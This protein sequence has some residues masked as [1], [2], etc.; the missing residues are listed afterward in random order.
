MRLLKGRQNVLNGFESKIFP[1]EKQTKGHPLD[2]VCVAKVSDRTCLKIITP[3]PMLEKLPIA[4]AQV[5]IG[6]ASENLL[7]EIRKITY[8]LHPTKEIL[9]KVYNEFN[10]G[11]NKMDI[12]FMDSGNSKTSDPHRL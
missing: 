4:F 10:K 12:I 1:I 7:N 9:K 5:N 3:K 6:D 2:L 8:S 11:I